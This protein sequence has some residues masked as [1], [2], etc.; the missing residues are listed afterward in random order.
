MIKKIEK[1]LLLTIVGLCVL[2]LIYSE[3]DTYSCQEKYTKT[4]NNFFKFINGESEKSRENFNK[5]RGLIGGVTWNESDR[6]TSKYTVME[7]KGAKEIYESPHKYICEAAYVLKSPEYDQSQKAYAI[8]LMHF[9]SI[10]DQIYLLKTANEAY[11]KGII[12]DKEVLAE[13]LYSPELGGASTNSRYT[14]LPA[15]R[16][17]FN[18]HANEVLDEKAREKV[19]SG[20]TLAWGLYGR[21]I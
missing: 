20:K 7:G 4:G 14:W 6:D 5:E 10:K 8:M 2:F 18:K 16:R 3:I 19:L 1:I 13:L 12:T 15:W 17:E 9:S 21:E 11:E